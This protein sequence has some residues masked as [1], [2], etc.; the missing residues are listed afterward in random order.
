MEWIYIHGKMIG[1]VLLE[2]ALEVVKNKKNLPFLFILSVAFPKDILGLTRSEI[3]PRFI[4]WRL[5]SVKV[6]PNRVICHFV[7]YY[8][9][10]SVLAIPTY[11]VY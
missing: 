3:R 1:S 8:I 2:L 6:Y 5:E 4:L 7:M 9:I 10:C 11:R